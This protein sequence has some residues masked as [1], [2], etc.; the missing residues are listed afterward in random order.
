MDVDGYVGEGSVGS[1]FNLFQEIM[2]NF[3][4][5][6]VTLIAMLQGCCAWESLIHGMQLHGYAIK[7]G[8][9]I[10]GLLQNS[11]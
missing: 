8:L 1:A 7:N 4:P 11:I 6:S 3:E 9:V 10:D 2:V 5:N